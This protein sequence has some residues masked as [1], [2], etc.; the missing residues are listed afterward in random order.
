MPLQEKHT[1][2]QM[3]QQYDQTPYPPVAIENSGK[4]DYDKLYISNLVTSYYLRNQQVISTKDKV[5]L[6]LACGSGYTTLVLA[7]TN[8]DAKIVGIDLSEKS[9]EVSKQRLEYHGFNNVE[10][11][12]MSIEDVAKLDLQFDYINCSDILYLL[13]DLVGSLNLLK[14]VLKPQ[15]ILR[16]NLHSKYQRNPFYQMQKACKLMGL[17]EEIPGEMEIEFIRALM[18]ALNNKTIIKITTWSEELDQS[19]I[20]IF[21]NYLL[22]GD[23]G[24]SIP[25][26][27]K[28]LKEADLE[29]INMTNWREWE[30]KNLF[31]Q[32]EQLPDVID[33]CLNEA[34][35]EEKLALFELFHPQHR[36]LDFWCGHP[37]QKHHFTPVSEWKDADWEKVKVYLHPL[38][39]QEDWKQS[40]MK[41]IKLFHPI[42][43]C[44]FLKR[45]NA[46]LSLASHVVSVLLPLWDRPQSVNDLIT[47]WQIVNGVDPISLEMITREEAKKQVQSVLTIL[48][49]WEYVLLDCS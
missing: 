15:G 34:T 43:I 12:V 1:E 26:M 8:P 37:E 4:N 28:A 42:E 11:N 46:T 45:A 27:F 36:L 39:Q 16:G 30:L 25:E 5:I 2:A 21:M 10:F 17:F 23:K 33:F 24:Y 38:L 6:D 14:S 18:N 47:R 31:K 13:D 7:Q 41:E 44:P 35:L 20:S 29:F 3:R 9:I 22:V 40:I 48:E 49:E 32:P 19:D